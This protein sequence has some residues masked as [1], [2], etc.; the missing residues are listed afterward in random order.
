MESVI[1][2]TDGCKRQEAP[3]QKL[4]YERYYGYA[5]KIVFRYVN[6]YEKAKDL[7][8]D[9]FIKIYN[10]IHLFNF[11]GS[12]LS[13]NE[14]LMLGW[15][16]RIMVNTAID[17]LRKNYVESFT[18]E[19]PDQIWVDESMVFDAGDKLLYKE[20]ILEIKKLSPSYRLIFNLFVIDG[21]KHHEIAKMLGISIGT[22]KSSLWK[23]RAHLMKRIKKLYAGT[24]SDR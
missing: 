10:N 24:D 13:D 16:K 4:Y 7:V 2:I 11:A 20:L 17:E 5:L 9:G 19:Y 1:T 21:Y 18:I 8:N 6:H 23:A 3:Y 12:T 22:S 15:V 14:R